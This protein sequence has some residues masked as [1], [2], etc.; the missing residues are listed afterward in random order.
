MSS[1]S[2]WIPW[3]DRNDIPKRAFL[4]GYDVIPM[5]PVPDEYLE[6]FAEEIKTN[7]LWHTED[8][9][10]VEEYGKNTFFV[11]ERY[12][13]LTKQQRIDYANY[14]NDI[15]E[16]FENI[17]ENPWNDKSGVVFN[18]KARKNL[19]EL[20]FHNYQYLCK[21][22]KRLERFAQ[23]DFEDKL[24]TS[25]CQGSASAPNSGDSPAAPAVSDSYVL[26]VPE[27]NNSND[28]I[29]HADLAK[30][31]GKK[32][33][34]KGEVISTDPDRYLRNLKSNPE[35][36]RKSKD[37]YKGK[38]GEHSIYGEIDSKHFY[39]Q[40]RMVKNGGDWSIYYYR[41]SLKWK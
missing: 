41:P 6:D 17:V 22:Q 36:C 27:F 15:N 8:L 35:T 11:I 12:N 4:I 2:G 23:N 21:I 5:H 25:A 39:V 13:N 32:K 29:S 16:W 10:E 3:K 24:K 9:T 37:K 33:T 31:I 18:W 1:E 19:R 40:W 38:R 34:D 28:W 14:V 20:L 26:S 7:C 30:E